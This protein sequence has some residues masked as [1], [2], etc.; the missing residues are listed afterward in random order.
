M[1]QIKPRDT[2]DLIRFINQHREDIIAGIY[3]IEIDPQ[4]VN[5]ITSADSMFLANYCKSSGSIVGRYTT[6]Q[7]ILDTLISHRDSDVLIAIAENPNTSASCLEILS[8][9]RIWGWRI[10]PKVAQHKNTSAK[11]LAIL[12]KVEDYDVRRKIAANMNT[13][14]D[15]LDILS[16]D[17]DCLVR[18]VV[19][20][21]ANTPPDAL[22][23]LSRDS[24]FTVRCNVASNL[25]TPIEVLEKLS[26]DSSPYVRHEVA[27]NP[28]ISVAI[29]EVPANDTAED[30][31]LVAQSI[32]TP[33]HVL[34]RLARDKDE[35]VREYAKKNPNT[36]KTLLNWWLD[37]WR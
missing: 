3:D 17:S 26:K 5:T 19:A 25:S 23:I 1:P 11:C 33:P 8:K 34:E 28:N 2:D 10:H 36:P 15:A 32:K 14:P 24:E 35:K 21:N 29:L 20:E 30:K 22:D 4:W 27:R 13:P 7:T 18:L 9:N 31:C 16:R 6:D 12:A 37:I